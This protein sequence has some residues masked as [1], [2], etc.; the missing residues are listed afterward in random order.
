MSGSN[1]QTHALH[2]DHQYQHREKKPAMVEALGCITSSGQCQWRLKLAS[3]NNSI[4][5]CQRNKKHEVP[6]KQT[7][8]ILFQTNRE[9]A[10]AGKWGGR[11]VVKVGNRDGDGN[12]KTQDML[13][14]IALLETQKIRVTEF[15]S[16]R[17]DQLKD[18]AEQTNSEFQQIA[19]DTVKD[20]DE[21]GLK[22]LES[23]EED[24]RACEEELASE[25]AELQR[26]EQQIDRFEKQ[27]WE[28]RN[29][30]LFFQR[31]YA[32]AKK[33]KEISPDKKNSIQMEADIL[34][35]NGQSL[36]CMQYLL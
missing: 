22:V 29:E 17:S 35:K 36:H 3:S 11:I 20:L 34:K 14:E 1:G 30:G 7:K 8:H 28:S 31:L 15:V 21:A 9:Y 33:L 13:A 24:V 16:E 5:F 6:T 2:A 4:S 26:K 12:E 19:D 27:S 25:R 32:P 18:M 10:N 23:V